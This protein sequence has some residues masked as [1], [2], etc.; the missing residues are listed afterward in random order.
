MARAPRGNDRDQVR[1]VAAG[2]AD[3]AVVNTYYLGILANSK[4]KKDRD[5]FNKVS[6]FFPNQNK[7]N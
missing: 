3:I 2:L 5:V 1:A 7:C 4:E 6:V